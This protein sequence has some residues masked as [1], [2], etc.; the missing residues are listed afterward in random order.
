MADDVTVVTVFH[1]R[2]ETVALSMRSLREQSAGGSKILAIDDGSSD[3]TF[4]RL[5]EFASDRVEVRR[6]PNTGFTKTMAALC[7]DVS[8]D[9][10]AVHGAGD[11]SLPDRIAEQSALLRANADLVAVGCGI[12][13][14]DYLTGQRWTVSPQA[15]VIAG[16]VLGDTGISHGELMFRRSAYVRTGGYRPFFHVGQASDLIY[17]LSRIGDLGFVREV[18]Y[19]RHLR[20]DGVNAVPLLLAEREILLA[21]ARDLHR[22]AVR[23]MD[24]QPG[25]A[26]PAIWLDDL[27]RYGP[28]LLLTAS[29]R[30]EI[31]RGITAAATT[32]WIA[33]ERLLA[34]RLARKS[35][36]EQP[37]ARALVLTLALLIG[38][39][40]IDAGCRS[41]L[42]KLSGRQRELSLQRLSKAKQSAADGREAFRGVHKSDR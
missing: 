35:L 12:E 15:A 36:A 38:R 1:N 16:P 22:K 10:V 39:G 11:E 30:P 2:A 5:R 34:L 24:G 33:G 31:A 17:R 13:N 9:F 42:I 19:R 21:L 7:A 3:D 40:P 23:E 28:L 14:V 37:T 26:A 27:D 20:A 4:A 18:L 25:Q 29:G 8:T 41:L 32:A 6:Q